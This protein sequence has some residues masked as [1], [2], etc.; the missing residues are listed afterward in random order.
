MRIHV[1]HKQQSFS[2]TRNSTRRPSLG[3][4]EMCEFGM[5]EMS[6]Y[7]LQFASKLRRFNSSTVMPFVLSH[8]CFSCSNARLRSSSSRICISRACWNCSNEWMG[9]AKKSRTRVRSSWVK[10][11]YLFAFL[12]ASRQLCLGVFEL[13][14]L[15][16]DLH[17]EHL[18][19]FSLHFLHLHVMLSFLFLHLRQ[20]IPAIWSEKG[21][22]IVPMVRLDMC[23]VYRRRYSLQLR[24]YTFL[25]YF[26][27]L[28]YVTE[29]KRGRLYVFC[30]KWM[31]RSWY[32][33]I[34]FCW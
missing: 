3:Q 25:F 27:V 9:F 22:T 20:W 10:S 4:A 31:I 12:V 18:L 34:A 26:L 29:M 7:S 2:S 28:S 16:L 23:R 19:H 24:Q 14:L 21:S 33:M 17:L 32:V 30:D 1:H 15:L 11:A 13:L 8:S 6:T 5:F